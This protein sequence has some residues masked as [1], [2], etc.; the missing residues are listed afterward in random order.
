MSPDREWGKIYYCQ[1][2][3]KYLSEEFYRSHLAIG[4]KAESYI[5]APKNV[6]NRTAP[7]LEK[8]EIV[9]LSDLAEVYEEEE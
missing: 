2:C 5:T 7:E 3:A 1:T 8:P 6:E 4:H 9:D